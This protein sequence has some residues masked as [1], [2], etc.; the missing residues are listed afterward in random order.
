[1]FSEWEDL[2][3]IHVSKPA[4]TSL[5]LSS[6][7]ILWI[8]YLSLSLSEKQSKALGEHPELNNMNMKE[9]Q[10]SW[11]ACPSLWGICTGS[12]ATVWDVLIVQL[13]I[14]GLSTPTF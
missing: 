14:L 11:K 10:G 4:M 2:S 7:P 1:M 6:D 13:L 12:K 5:P 3:E 9:K 8:E